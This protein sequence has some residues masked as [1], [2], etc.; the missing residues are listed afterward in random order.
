MTAPLPRP[1]G[2]LKS[3]YFSNY[4]AM[5][6][7]ILKMQ[8]LFT[9]VELDLAATVCLWNSEQKHFVECSGNKV[10]R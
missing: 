5:H 6:D 9:S 10:S 3:G 2:R 1:F 4:H 7:G 8:L